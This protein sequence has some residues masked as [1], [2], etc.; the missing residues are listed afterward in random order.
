MATCCLHLWLLISFLGCG[1]D[2]GGVS[3]MPL[4]VERRPNILVYL[5]DTLRQDR[6]GCYGYSRPTSPNIDVF[7][8]QATL[9]E[10][11]VG[12]SSWTRA[13]MASLFTGVWP[14]THG[15]TGWKHQL[16]QAFETLA[17]KIDAVGYQTA[18]FV[19]NPQI[20][21]RYGFGQG[22]DKFVRDIKKP[23]ADYNRMASDWLDGLTGDD[24]WFI[25]IHTMDPHAPYRPPEPYMSEFAPNDAQMPT[26][27]PR[28]KWP[29]EV[30]P[31]FSDRYDGEIAQNDASFGELMGILGSRGLYD[32][33]LIVFTSD[34][35]EEFK[36]HGR[37]RHGENLHAESLNVPIIVRFPGQSKGERV[38][39]AVQHIDLM[40]TILDYLGLE[41][42]EAVQGRSLIGRP[43]LEGE[44]YSHLFLSGFPLY[45]SVVDGEWKL[46]RRI[47]EN[48]TQTYQL[49]NWLEDAGETRD[50]VA[51]KP[52]RTAALARLLEDRLAAEEEIAA[53]E[54]IP[55]T[56]ELQEELEALGYLQ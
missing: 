50:L 9:F 34:H 52:E 46:I 36:E 13:S 45:H 17:E 51:E 25:Y 4:Q 56:E 19:G 15:T 55:L 31:F 43:G 37:W 47:D 44:I 42:P 39:A 3:E 12:Q 33:T 54:E 30:L 28:W 16:P 22:F 48:G 6:L 10:N 49:Y 1:S 14:P 38:A 26:W 35:G 40:P 23:S 18:A 2:G 7:A 8:T 5:V 21:V 27:E 53:A 20:T 32:D 29:L 41:I 24:P 11:G